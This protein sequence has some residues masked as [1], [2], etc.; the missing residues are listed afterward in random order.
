MDKVV[1]YKNTNFIIA[2]ILACLSFVL[3]TICVVTAKN[4]TGP[5][6]PTWL[7]NFSFIY[8]FKTILA[9][10][11]IFYF[12]TSRV[13]ITKEIP[14]YISI[15]TL[16]ILWYS[17]PVTNLVLHSPI[18]IIFSKIQGS[19]DITYE[20]RIPTQITWSIPMFIVTVNLLKQ[21]YS[22]KRK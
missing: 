8:W 5:F 12:F 2:E 9:V 15:S 14:R 16:M 1:G 18:T 4:A 13:F 21:L 20:S 10:V 17:I 6:A 11:G 22:I 19:S 7:P 3:N